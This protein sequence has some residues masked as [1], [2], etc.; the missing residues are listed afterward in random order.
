MSIE[1]SLFF[2][3]VVDADE[4]AIVLCDSHDIIVY[5]NPSA[6]RMYA[7]KGGKSLIGRSVISYHSEDTISVIRMISEWFAEN[8]E[9]NKVFTHHDKEKN[10]DLY[11][12]A[13]RDENKNLIGYY[14]KYE[15]RNPETI[16]RY[17]MD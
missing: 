15:N 8:P 5:M 7:D 6:I 16:P 12:I 14:E 11:M 1:L 9:N 10:V 13:L 2:K 4:N 3:S 17:Q